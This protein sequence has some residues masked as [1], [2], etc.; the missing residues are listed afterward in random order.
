LGE[1]ENSRTAFF[2]PV[3]QKSLRSLKPGEISDPIKTVNG[4][5]VIFLRKS[6]DL[7]PLTP[8]DDFSAI[9]QRYLQ[10]SQEDYLKQH[11]AL[12]LDSAHFEVLE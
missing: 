2:G 6:S 12:I 9:K 11:K 3:F 8:E 1:M 10:L 4:L 5:Y 7:R